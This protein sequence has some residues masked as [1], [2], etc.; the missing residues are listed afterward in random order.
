MMMDTLSLMTLCLTTTGRGVKPLQDRSSFL[1]IC[2]VAPQ[3]GAVE[4]PE[5]NRFDRRKEQTRQALRRAAQALILEKGFSLV[6]VDDIVRAADVARGTFYLHYRDKEELV[7]DIVKTQLDELD[8]ES[9]AEVGDAGLGRPA[10]LA[11][12]TAGFERA[13]RHRKF[14]L[15]V[16]GPRGSAAIAHRF[17]QQLAAETEREIAAGRFQP[18]A[19]LP[20][21]IVAQF[22]AGAVLGLI[23]WW[24][25]EKSE[26]SAEEMGKV[27]L[28]LLT[29]PAG[30]PAPEPGKRPRRRSRSIAK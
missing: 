2:P 27:T 21:P 5:K 23:T 8:A 3:I 26:L 24:L 17:H 20:A 1:T 19:H 4:L 15:L 11:A 18:G 22:Y 14:Y 25:E 30:L 9:A 7:W 28:A 10:Q 6:T 13:A 29:D 16:L 12:I